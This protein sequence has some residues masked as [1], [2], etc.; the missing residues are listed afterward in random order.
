[1]R[2]K[3]LIVGLLCALFAVFVTGCG[4]IGQVSQGGISIGSCPDSIRVVPRSGYIEYDIYRGHMDTTVA[5]GT[6]WIRRHLDKIL[7][8]FAPKDTVVKVV[9]LR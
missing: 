3:K 5:N 2:T 4:L 8:E 7:I 9:E 6:F 1:M